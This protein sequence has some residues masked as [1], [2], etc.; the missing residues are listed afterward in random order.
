MYRAR[1]STE[2]DWP[3]ARLVGSTLLQEVPFRAAHAGEEEEKEDFS[4]LC[5]LACPVIGQT[6]C[7]LTIH[8]SIHCRPFS[9]STVA[10]DGPSAP[11]PMRR[12]RRRPPRA[13]FR[14]P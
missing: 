13:P 12:S 14:R 9:P 4:E 10:T 8:C 7:I 6:P 11:R 2:N 5:V 1:R 3:A